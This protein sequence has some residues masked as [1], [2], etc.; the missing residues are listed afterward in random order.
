VT[1]GP[2]DIILSWKLF[3]PLSRLT[4]C[5][6]LSHYIILLVNIGSNR[7]PGYLSDYNVVSAQARIGRHSGTEN[8]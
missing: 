7:T 2:V 4:Y 5:A 3:L 6:Y 1:A 8:T